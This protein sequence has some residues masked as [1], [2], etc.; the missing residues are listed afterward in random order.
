MLAR[1][2]FVQPTSEDEQ[3]IADFWRF[4]RYEAT[5][6]DAYSRTVIA[7]RD[8]RWATVEPPTG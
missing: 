2:F 6:P 5:N 4:A 8:G 7:C 1:H 3:T